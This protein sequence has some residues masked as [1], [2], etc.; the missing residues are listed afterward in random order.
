MC[1]YNLINGTYASENSYMLDTVL[2]KIFKFDGLIVSDW[3]AVHNRYKALRATLDLEMPYRAEGT[4][5]VKEALEKG[6]ITEDDINTSVNRILD[7][8]DKCITAEK[9]VEF[10]KQQRHDNAVRIAKEGIV[11]L[12]NDGFLPLKA[13]KSYIV[14]NTNP[15]IGG[16]GSSNVTYDYAIPKLAPLLQDCMPNNKFSSIHLG[17][18]EQNTYF[19]T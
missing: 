1:S 14:G 16:I 17:I 7:L 18:E 9:K 10:T 11:L 8:I 13:K 3:W 4:K 5:E 6:Y 12:K 19:F 2:R 15:V